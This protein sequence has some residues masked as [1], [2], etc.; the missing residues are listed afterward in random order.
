MDGPV[1]LAVVS[2]REVVTRGVVAMVSARP[3]LVVP[4]QVPFSPLGIG[5][6][7]V[8][9]VDGYG[10]GD[11][12]RRTCTHLHELA[13]TPLVVLLD[14]PRSPGVVDDGR[15]LGVAGFLPAT[16]SGPELLDAVVRVGRGGMLPGEQPRPDDPLSDRQ[17]QILGLIVEGLDN[18]AIA[19][20][21]VISDNTL[22]TH[23][24]SVYRKLDVTSRSQ[25]V[26]WG[27]RHGYGSP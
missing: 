21:L 6:V 4:L 14:D 8:V 27:L 11:V 26:A 17:R 24:R 13:P 10:G 12:V 5:R 3:D 1:Q 9:V 18:R 16:V 19:E 20:Q 22:K 23:V 15:S 7:D 25:A 2:D